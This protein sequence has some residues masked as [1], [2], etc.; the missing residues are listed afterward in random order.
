MSVKSSG[1]AHRSMSQ[2]MGLLHVFLTPGL[3]I[4]IEAK[5]N[6]QLVVVWHLILAVR[7]VTKGRERSMQIY[8]YFYLNEMNVSTIRKGCAEYFRKSSEG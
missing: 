2:L 4:L 6:F 7:I 5:I 1:D 8:N 3:A